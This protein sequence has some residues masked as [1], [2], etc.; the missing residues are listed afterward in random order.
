MQINKTI[1]K[2]LKKQEKQCQYT[3]NLCLYYEKLGSV[4]YDISKISKN[5]T[6][7]FVIKFGSSYM[8]HGTYDIH[9]ALSLG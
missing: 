9:M 2:P 1:F 8:P 7:T 6:T 3:N 4:A 5:I